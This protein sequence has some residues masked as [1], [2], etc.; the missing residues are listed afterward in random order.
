MVADLLEL[1]P[2]PQP[3]TRWQHVP[4][5]LIK[6][7]DWLAGLASKEALRLV[8]QQGVAMDIA[9]PLKVD[10]QS[11]LGVRLVEIPLWGT[12]STRP[13]RPGGMRASGPIP[14][15]C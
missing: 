13:L 7:A 11:D 1:L 9:I 12:P 6:V 3:G 14:L 5:E 10:V 15:A 4:R 8:G 2:F